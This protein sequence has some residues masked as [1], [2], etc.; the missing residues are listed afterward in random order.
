[1]AH[2][3]IMGAGIG[4]VSAAYSLRGLLGTEHRITVVNPTDYFQFT[5]SNPW[6]AVG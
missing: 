2:V 1:M 5:P 4:G 6:V 3:I